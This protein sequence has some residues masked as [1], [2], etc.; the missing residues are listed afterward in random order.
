[1]KTKTH[2][3][4]NLAAEFDI[5]RVTAVRAL[6]GV[7][8]DETV[9]GRSTYS[10][11]TFARALELHR[12]ANASNNDGATDGTSDTSSLM[13]ARV[14]ITLANAEAR[15][16]DNLIAAAKLCRIEDIGIEFAR[17]KCPSSKS[18]GGPQQD[19]R[20]PGATQRAGSGRDFGDSEA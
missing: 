4:N 14:R 2:S 16:R 8:P 6:K 20:Q 10:I 18:A 5:D 7:E 13:Q 11:A 3:T 15:K 9:S 12:L 17:P 19:L 1:M